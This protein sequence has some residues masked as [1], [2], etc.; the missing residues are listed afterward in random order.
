MTCYN[1]RDLT[2]RCLAAILQQHGLESVKVDVFLVDDRCS[3]G[4]GDAVRAAFPQVRVLEGT[5][6][7]FWN[8]GMHLAFSEAVKG[9]YDFY[10]WLNDDTTLDHD[11]LRRLL[12]TYH[13]VTRD[14]NRVKIVAGGTRDPDSGQFTYGGVVRLNR[15]LWQSFRRI[16][17]ANRPVRCEATNGN[18]VLIPREVVSRI[19]V[20]DPIFQHRW[21]DHDYCFRT[22]NGGGEVWLTEGYVGSCTWNSIAGTWRDPALPVLRRFRQLWAPSGLQ[23]KDY[24]VYV[25]RHRGLL[26][27]WF[28]VSPFIKILVTSFL[29]R[30][31]LNGT[32]TSDGQERAK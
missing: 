11:A 9:G 6:T 25:R 20:L 13:L 27:P 15:Y 32:G 7:L 22:C 16:A 23:P 31:R 12:D 8:R 18:C 26:W 2:L 17:P 30:M 1:R 4:T 3:D 5:G 14:G 28:W 21:G 29:H 19:G 24:L 10:L